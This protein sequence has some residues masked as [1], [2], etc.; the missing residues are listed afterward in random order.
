MAKSIDT[1]TEDI[2]GLFKQEETFDVRLFEQFGGNLRDLMD[3][4]FHS[5]R[6]SPTLR[7]SNIGKPDRQLWYDMNWKGPIEEI[8]P[9]TFVKFS[10]GD[11]IEQMLILYA[12]MAG[13]DVQFEQGEIEVDGIKGHLDCIIDGVVTDVK[14]TSAFAF[15]KFESGSLLEPGNDPFGYVGQLAGYVHAKTPGQDGCFLAANKE[16]GKLAL[17]RVPASVLQQ[18]QVEERITHVKQ[19]VTS[20][21]PPPRCYPDKP[22]GK[23]GNRVLSTG[24]SY[25]QH[26]FHCWDNL[27]TYIYSSGPKYFTHVEKTPRVSE[28]D[29]M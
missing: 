22:D 18:Y 19:M 29:A 23:S 16:L 20:D 15:K 10:Y 14:S 11:I 5:R 12:K 4:R 1:L 8:Q 2:Y 26:R 28:F 13:H 27:K 3:Y 7:M 24:C 17:L 9:H 6:G 25:C 21:Q